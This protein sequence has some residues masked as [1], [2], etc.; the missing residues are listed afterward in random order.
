MVQ[1]LLLYSILFT[2]LTGNSVLAQDCS[3]PYLP[4]QFKARLAWRSSQNNTSTAA[5]PVVAN[6]NPQEDSLPEIVVCGGNGQMNWDKLQFYRGD[7]TNATAPFVQTI[8]GSFD[9]YPAPTPTIGDVDN[10]GIPELLISCSDN[11]IRVFNHYTENPTAPMNLWI[12][13]TGNIEGEDIRLSLADFDSDG[14]PE[15][16]AG[17][18]IFKFDFSNPAAPVL[19]KILN[20]LADRGQSSF[21]LYSELACNPTAVDIF[22]VAECNGDPDCGVL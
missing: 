14:T 5:T 1:K 8:P 4:S 12:V 11:R 6:L 17:N 3:I 19:A 16:Y 7:G 21:S 15:V 18:D 22:T 10:D 13:S 9:Y 2:I 20:G